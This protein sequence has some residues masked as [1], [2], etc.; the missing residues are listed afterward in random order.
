MSDNCLSG[1]KYCPECGKEL[2]VYDTKCKYCGTKLVQSKLK[3]K[4]KKKNN[5][6]TKE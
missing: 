2:E 6:R 4:R 1:P 3:T 5:Y